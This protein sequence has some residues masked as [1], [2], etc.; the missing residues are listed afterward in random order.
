MRWL[1]AVGV[2]PSSEAAREKLPCLVQAART[3]SESSEGSLLRTTHLKL[4]FK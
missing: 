2:I 4:R 3:R 1:T